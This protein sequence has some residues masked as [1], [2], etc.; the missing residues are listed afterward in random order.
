MMPPNSF[1]FHDPSTNRVRAYFSTPQ[2]FRTT[3]G[4][5]L[6]KGDIR[7]IL[8]ELLKWSWSKHTA[9]SLVLI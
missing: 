9:T 2:G 7:D 4:V 5:N 8:V 3:H 1:L 6:S